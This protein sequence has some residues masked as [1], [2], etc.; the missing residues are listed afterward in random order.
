MRFL[1]LFILF[2]PTAL[3]AQVDSPKMGGDGLRIQIYLDQKCF[4]PG[5]LDGRPGNFTLRAVYSF[6]RFRGRPPGAWDALLKEAEEEIKELFALATVPALA[7]DY[8]NPNLPRGYGNL[9]GVKLL[10]LIH[11]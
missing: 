7:K 5:Y 1:C 6:N 3:L 11:I 10:S 9:G 8:I 2:L 4:G